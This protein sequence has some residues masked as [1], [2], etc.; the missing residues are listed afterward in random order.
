VDVQAHVYPYTAG[1][2][3]L[4]SII[5]PWAQEGGTEEMFKRIKDMSLRDRLVHDIENGIDGWYDHYTAVGKDWSRMQPVTF[6]NPAYRKYTGKRMDVII[7]D[8]KKPPLEALFQILLDNDGSVPTVYFHHSEQDMRLAMQTPWVSFGSDGTALRADG[9]L[10]Q[11]SPHPRSY[12]T[13]PRIM[14]RY[15][16]EEKVITLEDAVRKATSHNAAKVRIFDRGLLRPGMW[17]DITV[18]NPDTIIDKA[19]YDNPHQYSVGVEYVI[20]NGKLVID[21]G[22]HT[23]ARPGTVLYGPGKK[24]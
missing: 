16:R 13:Y 12:G 3:N 9:P 8:M 5:P 20:V 18:F 21:R 19:T 24:G 15:V 23:G 14:G 1:Q 6:S 11:G 10:S 2:N 17:A 22:K 4:R 7:A